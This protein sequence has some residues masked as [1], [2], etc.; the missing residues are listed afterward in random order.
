MTNR[1]TFIKKISQI[2]LEA[3]L[4]EVST[5]PKPGLVTPF[6]NGSHK[7]MSYVTFMKSASYIAPYFSE[8]IN[9]G[10]IYSENI[11]DKL[12]PIGLIA[13]KDMFYATDGVN[14]HKGLIFLLGVICAGCGVLFRENKAINRISISKIVSEITEGIVEREL[15]NYDEKKGM[16]NGQRIYKKY[17]LTGIRGE[18]EGGLKSI[19]DYALPTFEKYNK[20]LSINDTLVNTL[21]S[22]MTVVDDTTV[23][24]RT[25]IEGLNFVKKHSKIA[26]ELGGMATKEGVDYIENLDRKFKERN[27]SPG[28]CADLLAA[29]YMIYKIE[30]IWRNE[31]ADFTFINYQSQQEIY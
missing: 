5:H 18:V 4:L 27:I 8:F 16:T 9:I 30:A 25:S 11:L 3:T 26:L 14:T 21:L 22:L 28:G 12:R 1:D 20:R 7:D 23:V 19:I 17:G 31:Y 15:N 2:A 10:I 13:E 29:T 6:S 24:H